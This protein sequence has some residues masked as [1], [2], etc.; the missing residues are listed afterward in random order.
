MNNKNIL[1]LTRTMGVGG[2]EKVII[3]LC[4]YFNKRFNKIIVCSCGGIYEAQLDELGIKH[5]KINDIEKKNPINM[6]KTLLT[7][8]KIIKSE[9]INIVHTHHRMAAFYISIIRKFMKFKFIHT[10]HNTFYDKKYLTKFALKHAHI[11]AVGEKVKANLIEVYKISD[12]KIKVIYNGV[13]EF[14]NKIQE[15][16]EIKKAKEIGYFTVGNIGRLNEQKGVEYYIDSIPKVLEKRNDIMF[17]I[18]GDGEEREKLEKI[19]NDKK[20]KNII[21]LGYRNDINNIIKQLDLVVLSSLWEGLPL[22]PIE[23]F[24]AGKTI[25]ATDVDG[26]SEIVKNEYNG[27]LIESRNSEDIAENII[28]L[29][30]DNTLKGNLERNAYKTYKDKFSLETF[31]KNYE[32]YYNL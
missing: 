11:I 14:C 18:I 8:V 23:T 29:Y 28:R 6:V 19:A 13:G 32:K 7:V 16:P 10:Q 24:S 25:I 26:T 9:N 31:N 4:K 30:D 5:Y 21:F 22:I 20:I 15:V 3:Q 2:T 27:L 17:Y 1:Y 12:S